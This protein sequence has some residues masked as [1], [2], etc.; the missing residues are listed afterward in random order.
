MR[1]PFPEPSCRP[2]TEANVYNEPIPR[3]ARLPCGAP[4][5]SRRSPRRL[6]RMGQTDVSGA[7]ATDVLCIW[8]YGA[9]RLHFGADQ[10]AFV[11]FRAARLRAARSGAWANRTGVVA[12]SPRGRSR[13]CHCAQRNRTG[14]SGH[15][16]Y[17]LRR[18]VA[19]SVAAH[20]LARPCGY[21]R[22]RHAADMGRARWFPAS[23]L[24]CR[25]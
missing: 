15:R 4:Q 25:F 7:V 12:R 8:L 2:G 5:R 16:R 24:V 21:P 18:A 10:R 9:A 1:W 3:C 17:R 20:P 6:R 22:P 13:L 19:R 23:L 14:Y 11:D